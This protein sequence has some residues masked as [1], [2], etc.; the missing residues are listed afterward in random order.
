MGG[1]VGVIAGGVVG[2]VVGAV[3]GILGMENSDLHGREAVVNKD[4]KE[5]K[6]KRNK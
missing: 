2:G 4:E 6:E 3:A 5:E 1:S